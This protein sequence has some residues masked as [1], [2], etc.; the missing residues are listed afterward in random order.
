MVRFSIYFKSRS[1][2]LIETAFD[3]DCV[4]K[5]GIKDEPKVSDPNDW[6]NASIII[7]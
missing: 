6:M 2:L 1:H 7:R 5:R 4:Y 3:I